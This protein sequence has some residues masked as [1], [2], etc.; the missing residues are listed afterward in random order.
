MINEII[1]MGRRHI[2]EY[3]HQV[4]PPVILPEFYSAISISDPGSESPSFPRWVHP[5]LSLQFHDYIP[6]TLLKGSRNA[7]DKILRKNEQRK[8]ESDNIILPTNSGAKKI[9]AFANSLHADG[10]RFTLFISSEHG[11]GRAAAVAN[12]L[13]CIDPAIK[14]I[15]LA[16]NDFVEENTLLARLLAH[17]YGEM[18]KEMK[19]DTNANSES[20]V[21]R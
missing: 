18:F 2:S 19:R 16:R 10:K 9:I 4:S 20:T 21:R 5:I 1:F 8:I 13:R 17:N 3:V 6:K 15:G 12:F 11:R 7:S 14:T